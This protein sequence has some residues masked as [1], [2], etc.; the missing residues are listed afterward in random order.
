MSGNNQP[1]TLTKLKSNKTIETLTSKSKLTILSKITNLFLCIQKIIVWFITKLNSIVS[2]C[3]ILT[4]FTIILIPF[5][6]IAIILIF[7][8]HF[9]FYRNLYLF[10]F[11]KGIKEEFLDNYI[12]EIDDTKAELNGFVTK[13]NYIDTENQL[14]FEIYYKEFAS[15]GLLD[16]QDKRTFPNIS[17]HSE[18]MYLLIDKFFKRIETRDVYTIPKEISKKYIDDRKDPIGELA[19]LYY[20]MIPIITHGS[21]LMNAFINESFYIAYEFNPTDRTIIDENLFFMLPRNNETFNQNDNFTPN[22]ILLN[23][24]I[25]ITHFEHTELKSNSYYNEN[26]F[27]K[28]DNHFRETVNVSRDGYSNISLAHLNEEYNGKINKSLIIT[29]QQYIKSNNNR[30]FIINIIF[31]LCKGFLEEDDNLFTNFIVKTNPNNEKFDNEKYSDNDT[32]VVLK[33]DIIEYSLSLID[34][35]Y[36][37]YGL[38]DKNSNFFKNGVSYDSFNLDF[39]YDPFEFYTSIENFEIDF[40]YLSAYYLYKTLFQTTNFSVIKKNREE[41]YLFNFD[42][43]EKIQNICSII[44]FKS[45]QNYL[46][47]SGVNCWE[48]G[49]S[50]YYSKEEFQNIS[51][52]D[53][54]SKYP[55][56]SC[57]PLY[58][59]KNYKTIDNN[60]DNIVLASEIN[61]PSKCQNKFTSDEIETNLN[62]INNSSYVKLPKKIYNLIISRLNIPTTDYIKI[63]FENLNQLPGY[64]FLVMT[65]IKMSISLFWYYLYSSITQ[66]EI[67]ILVLSITILGSIICLIIMYVNLRRYSTI[68]KDFKKMHEMYV[69]HSDD[70]SINDE[71]QKNKN[72]D[73]GKIERYNLNNENMPLLQN[74]GDIV[75][76]NDNTL[77]DDLFTMFCKHYKLNRK[78][79][80]EYYSQQK[81]ETKN[82][83]KLKMMKEK[84]ELFKLLSMFSILAP[85]FRLNLSL[86]YKMYNYSKIIKKYDQYVSQVININKEQ[87][88]LTQNILYELLSTENITDYGLISNLNFKYI[89]N[90]RAE[91]K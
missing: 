32:F 41:I 74:E 77:L 31:F 25:N 29:S 37:H 8:A 30:Y 27:M 7:C 39:L 40:K 46:Q 81:H 72:N 42:D 52:I 57:I 38:S 87:T 75:S 89:S 79:L 22:N 62:Y 58:C 50:I 26:W 48:K 15:I 69:F 36:F 21:Y 43:E 66:I 3:S 35:Q 80:E 23:P 2:N 73:I 59:L 4:Q 53:I 12:T 68:I 13:E 24:L 63:K 17:A 9:I 60:Y 16:I 76:A 18:N 10:N 61:L 86:N 84:N 71:N 54:Y 82:Q 11:Q 51:M 90:I 88:R 65:Q 91:L 67:I 70:N 14:F 64:Y 5:S 28:Q 34:H 55:Y 44:N 45:Y 6:I 19:K 49:N 78:D 85:S 47:K 83:M 1:E 20:Y 56:C 33:S